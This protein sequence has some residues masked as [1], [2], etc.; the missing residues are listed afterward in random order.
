MCTVLNSWWWTERP[1]ET[2]RVIFNKLENY[3][4]S[5]FYY[6]NIS[7]CT[8]PWSSDLLANVARKIRCL[9]VPAGPWSSPCGNFF[10]NYK[11]MCVGVMLCTSPVTYGAWRQVRVVRRMWKCRNI[12]RC[13][14]Y[15]SWYNATSVC[16]ILFTEIGVQVMKSI[17]FSALTLRRLMSY[18]YIYI[19]IWSTHSWC[20]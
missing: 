16:T 15:S 1:T 2:C 5:W 20:F 8:V 7:R 18:I 4:S 9:T 10:K 6:R 11:Q 17:W 12:G 13:Y 19:Y 14:G 3:A